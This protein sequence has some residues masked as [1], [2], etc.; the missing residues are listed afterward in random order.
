M[1]NLDTMIDSYEFS[2]QNYNDFEDV[3][4]GEVD[5]EDEDLLYRSKPKAPKR[6]QPKMKKEKYHD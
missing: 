5:K 1:K 4:F 2:E 6:K 3:R